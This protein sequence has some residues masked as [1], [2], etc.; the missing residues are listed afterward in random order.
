MGVDLAGI[1]GSALTDASLA[2]PESPTDGYSKHLCSSAQHAAVIA[3]LGWAE[4]IGAA[5]IFV[6]VNIVDYSGYPD[7]RP[8]FIPRLR[9]GAA[10]HQGRRRGSP[11]SDQCAAHQD[12]EG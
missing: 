9:R 10:R 8:E 7:C 2:V 12:V 11:V 1:G 3:G 4:V 6:G 5:D